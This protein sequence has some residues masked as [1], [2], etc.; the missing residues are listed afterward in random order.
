[1][2]SQHQE[3]L[4]HFGVR[5]RCDDLPALGAEYSRD[6]RLA[7]I[8]HDHRR[9]VS[10]SDGDLWIGPLSS[11]VSVLLRDLRAKARD[12]HVAEPWSGVTQA[13]RLTP[14]VLDELH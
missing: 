4:P 14:F 3:D 12:A 6:G 1:V 8:P 7:R 10:T 5:R 9:V 13:S 2:R 11:S